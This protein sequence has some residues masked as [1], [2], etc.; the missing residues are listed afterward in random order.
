VKHLVRW[1][2]DTC[3]DD[4]MNAVLDRILDTIISPELLPVGKSG[5]IVQS[6]E[7]IVGPYE[8]HDFFLYHRQRN[9]FSPTKVRALA[10]HAFDGRFDEQ[11]ITRWVRVFFERFARQQF[12]RT[13]LPPGPK[14][15]SVSLSP[16]G[17]LRLP[18]ELDALIFTSELPEAAAPGT[19]APLRRGASTSGAAVP[20]S[21]KK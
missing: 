15:G 11:T 16:R 21:R 5:E 14:I 3:G 9:G 7:D 20:K 10:L 1:Y 6:T 13:T 12:K 2:G 4:A 19:Q 18:D 17:D 8:L